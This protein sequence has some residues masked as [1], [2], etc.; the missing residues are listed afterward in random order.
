VHKILAVGLVGAVYALIGVVMSEAYREFGQQSLRNFPPLVLADRAPLKLLPGEVEQEDTSPPDRTRSEPSDALAPGPDDPASPD[1]QIVPAIVPSP[2]DERG[3]PA[4]PLG[5]TERRAMVR[6][7]M[8]Q[9]AGDSGNSAHGSVAVPEMAAAPP[10]GSTDASAQTTVADPSPPAPALKPLGLIPAIVVETTATSD[11]PLGAGPIRLTALM[12]DPPTPAL[13]PIGVPSSVRSG[14]LP[15]PNDEAAASQVVARS[16][17]SLPDALRALW[18]NLKILA[19]GPGSR[20]GAVGNRGGENGFKGSAGATVVSA[21]DTGGAGASSSGAN[22]GAGGANGGGGTT[23]GGAAGASGGNTGGSASGGSNASGGE[24]GGASGGSTGGSS[25]S[26]GSN[27][28]GGGVG[29]ASGG[30]NSGSSTGAGAGPGGPGG[31]A[32]P[33]GHGGGAGPGG[34]GG[35]AG[36]GGHGGGAGPGGHGGGAGPGGHGGGANGGGKGDGGGK[37]GGSGKGH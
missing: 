33:G 37:G 28:S 5:T 24:A 31:G 12:F 29:G 13:K 11:A 6:Q 18:S 23:G 9:H 19:S 10:A 1:S 32:G 7:D 20:V 34:H 30:K 21:V 3:S 22:A 15:S 17:Q 26:G 25:A 36:P 8:G 4:D 27:A 35:G 14:P 16:K 2:N